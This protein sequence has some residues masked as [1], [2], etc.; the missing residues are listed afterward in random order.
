MEEKKCKYL[1][2]VATDF[3]SII[4]DIKKKEISELN[5][6]YI[7]DEDKNEIY[8]LHDYNKDVESF[9]N[10]KKNYIWKKKGIKFYL[11]KTWNY[12]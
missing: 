10:K 1:N 9:R 5:C 6:I 3:A 8:L 4:D 7:A 12:I 2:N 11:K